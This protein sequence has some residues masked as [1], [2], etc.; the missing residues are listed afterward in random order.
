[1]E[2]NKKSVDFSAYT[3]THTHG[4]IHTYKCISC[5]N[6]W[7]YVRYLCAIAF[8]RN[9]NELAFP[10]AISVLINFTSDRST[11]IDLP[12]VEELDIRLSI[13]ARGI[14]R[15]FIRERDSA[16]NASQKV[17]AK[18]FSEHLDSC[19]SLPRGKKIG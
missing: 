15:S 10:R 18:F 19:T 3:H 13:Y 16:A 7:S 12:L 4:H 1:M 9:F 8:Y 5:A 11:C 6:V 2:Q 17:L 14:V